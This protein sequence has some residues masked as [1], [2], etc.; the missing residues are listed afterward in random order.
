MYLDEEVK[1]TVLTLNKEGFG[2]FGSCQGH[3]ENNWE[4]YI[5]FEPNEKNLKFLAKLVE[6]LNEKIIYTF[7]FFNLEKRKDETLLKWRN[8]ETEDVFIN[9]TLLETIKEQING[10]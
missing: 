3:L 9:Q 2:T 1:E 6:E 5:S 7:H 8:I 4:A 10:K